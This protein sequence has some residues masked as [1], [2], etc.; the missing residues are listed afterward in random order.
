MGMNSSGSRQRTGRKT[1]GLDGEHGRESSRPSSTVCCPRR[2]EYGVE[3]QA[4]NGARGGD[5]YWSR[6]TGWSKGLVSNKLC[7]NQGIEASL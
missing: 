2:P 3:E 4:V 6:R 5:M 7:N 1:T